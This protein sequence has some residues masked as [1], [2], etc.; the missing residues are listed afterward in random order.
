MNLFRKKLNINKLIKEINSKDYTKRFLIMLCGLFISSFAFNLFFA[1]NNIVVGG[2]S[3]LSLIIK[4]Y[5]HIKPSLFISIA[6]VFLII[7]SFIFIGKEKTLNTLIVVI[8]Y[9]IFIEATSKITNHIDL[10]TSS[11]LLTIIFGGALD[12]LASG[13]I[14]KE[15]FSAGG[16]QIITQIMY[17]YLHMS[18]GKSSLI[19]NSLIII[20]AIFTFGITKSM[21]AVIALYISSTITDRV[22]LGVSNNKSFYIITDKEEEVC[23][24]IIQKLHHSVTI[25]NAKGGY[26]NKNKKLLLCI[27]PTK[28]YFLVKEVVL[29]IDKNAFFLIT[30]SYE[31]VG[32]A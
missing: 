6:S 25:I 3:G 31:A 20:T 10:E 29:E 28:E 21:Y 14:L 24:F 13:L 2:I 5:F 26:S 12:G 27:I 17:K 7:I 4:E 8:I 22:I 11:L 15:G 30:D 19:V 9:P 16:T 1:P 32:G 23:E 18:L